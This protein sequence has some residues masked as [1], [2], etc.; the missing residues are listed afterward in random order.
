VNAYDIMHEWDRAAGIDPR[1]DEDLDKY[2]PAL[3]SG[4]DYEGWKALLEARNIPAI[5]KGMKIWNLPLEPLKPFDVD[6]TIE[7]AERPYSLD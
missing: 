3:L 7:T 4:D 1:S 6:D 2:V 5:R